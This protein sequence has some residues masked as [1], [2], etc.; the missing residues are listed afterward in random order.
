MPQK[1]MKDVRLFKPTKKAEMPLK[2]RNWFKA[3]PT[4][5]Q[6]NKREIESGLNLKRPEKPDVAII[7]PMVH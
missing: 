1:L 4:G 7:G 5:S 2:L 6:H 3:L